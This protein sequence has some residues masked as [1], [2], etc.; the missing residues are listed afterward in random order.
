M[1]RTVARARTATGA[2]TPGPVL[3]G[4]PGAPGIGV[5]R[6]LVVEP[7]GGGGSGAAGVGA[8]PIGADAVGVPADP[9]AEADRLRAALETAAAELTDLAEQ[10][11]TRAGEE[12]GA[13]FVAQALFARDPGIVDPTLDEISSGIP[14]ADAIMSVTARPCGQPCRRRR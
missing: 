10:T 12:V 5:G 7:P 13:I 3:V 1:A 8:S 11:T 4:R 2:L 9:A 14:A 6:A